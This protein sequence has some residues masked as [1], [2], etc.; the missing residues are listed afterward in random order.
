MPASVFHPPWAVVGALITA[1]S[2][3]GTSFNGTTSSNGTAVI[4][5]PF[6]K[7]QCPF[8]ISS[9]NPPF[10]PTPFH[11]VCRLAGY[12]QVTAFHLGSED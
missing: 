3:N 4:C 6:A 5:G 10:L 2:S 12:Q 8:L 9:L 11:T 1:V 7:G